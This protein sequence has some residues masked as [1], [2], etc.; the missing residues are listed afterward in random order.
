MSQFLGFDHIDCRVTSLAAIEP[1]YDAVMPQLGLPRKR[2]CYVDDAGE[3]HE[4]SV[5]HAY[6]AVEYY[7]ESKA[8]QRRFVPRPDRTGRSRAGMDADRLPGRHR[9]AAGA[10]SSRSLDCLGWRRVLIRASGLQIERHGKIDPMKVAKLISTAALIAAFALPMAA[11]AQQYPQGPMQVQGQQQNSKGPQRMYKRWTRLLSGINLSSQQQQQIQSALDQF[12]QQ[13]PAGSPRDPQATRSL[14]EQI[15]GLLTP[16]QQTALRQ[17]IQTLK[18]QRQQKRL[19]RLEQQ[20][21]QGATQGQ[22][23]PAR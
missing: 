7:E 18:I 10:R 4:P 8:R 3:W 23:P 9:E 21:Q 13:H 5:R 15:F 14:R 11:A 20:Q 1:F 17:Q 12:A 2:Y 6:N 22:V 16:A 19:Q